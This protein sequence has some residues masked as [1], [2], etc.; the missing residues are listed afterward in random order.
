MKMEE[1]TAGILAGGMSSRMG[2]NKSFLKMGETTL[3]EHLIMVCGD[4]HEVILSANDV[5][6]YAPYGKRIVADE[7]QQTGP[8]E[9]VYQILSAAQT[10]K[11]LILATDM[12]GMT[13][14]FLQ[15]LCEASGME[16][17]LIVREEG[18][19]HP[20]CGIY[21]RSALDGIVKMREHGER[22]MRLLFDRVKTAY[23]D[24]PVRKELENINT[25]KEY[26]QWIKGYKAGGAY[27]SV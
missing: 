21:D 9:G 10:D 7:L 20:L 12:P 15:N 25:P 3:L 6:R 14:A 17:C 27:D 5:V 24:V 11:V 16:D 2:Q 19:L 22:K 1:M 26:E 18:Q 13:K 23:Y 8:L 4:F